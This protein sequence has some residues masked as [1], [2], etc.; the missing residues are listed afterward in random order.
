MTA[1]QQTTYLN[2]IHGTSTTLG[3]STN[4]NQPGTSEGTVGSTTAAGH[5]A[6]PHDHA[7][8][9]DLVFQP[10]R[11]GPPPEELEG[12]KMADPGEGKVMT[13]Q[14][15]KKRAGWGGEYSLTEGL[16]RKKR[17]QAG[18]RERLEEERR[19]GRDVDGGGRL[20][21]ADDDTSAV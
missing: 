19:R 16:E 21:A 20:R 5:G 2:A 6:H 3:P 1:P 8:A 18:M 13:E 4:T 12:D 10:R 15:E 17:E 7:N 9:S 14:L 11:V